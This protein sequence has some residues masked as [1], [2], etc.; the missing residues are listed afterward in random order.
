MGNKPCLCAYV[1]PSLWLLTSILQ[2][3]QLWKRLGELWPPMPWP[4]LFGWLLVSKLS[5]L[6]QWNVLSNKPA[7]QTGQMLFEQQS[8]MAFIL[9]S[10]NVSCNR[11]YFNIMT[12]LSETEYR[13]SKNSCQ[14][15][16]LLH[17]LFGSFFFF[18]HAC[19]RLAVRV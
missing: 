3:L 8:M 7:K 9:S 18:S 14:G 11:H 6:R 10:C 2:Y 5:L 4:P 13:I 15:L 17:H 1:L 19:R 16:I 12:F